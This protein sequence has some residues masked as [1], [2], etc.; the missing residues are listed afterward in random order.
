M[1]RFQDGNILRGH[2]S[3]SC[4]P[5]ATSAP[6]QGRRAA[7]EHR[8]E[9]T[10]KSSDLGCGVLEQVKA[11]ERALAAC[12]GFGDKRPASSLHIHWRKVILG[13]RGRKTDSALTDPGALQTADSR[14]TALFQFGG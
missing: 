10:H 2:D 9:L 13:D 1:F 14:V 8:A 7:P 5:E 12:T 6:G 3:A 4:T 11:E